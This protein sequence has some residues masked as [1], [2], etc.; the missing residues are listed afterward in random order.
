[1]NQDMGRIRVGRSSGSLLGI[2]SEHYTLIKHG[3]FLRASYTQ[4]TP[5]KPPFSFRKFESVV[6]VDLVSPVHYSNS[7]FVL[8]SNLRFSFSTCF[9]LLHDTSDQTSS[10]GLATLANVKS[11]A[12]FDGVG[13][14]H[15]DNHLNVVTRHDH[16]TG[17][18]L[19]ALGKS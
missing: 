14:G 3:C 1:M 8:E 9:S 10:N 5:H 7:D 13:V 19:G 17:G 18:I 6:S 11:L 15:V 16:L 2:Y 12:D 4:H